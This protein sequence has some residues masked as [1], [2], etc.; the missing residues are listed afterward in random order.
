MGGPSVGALAD[1]D[2]APRELLGSGSDE[3]ASTSADPQ[4]LPR[5]SWSARCSLLRGLGARPCRATDD[6]PDRSLDREGP[7]LT[8]PLPPCRACDDD[9]VRRGRPPRDH[10]EA[11]PG[12]RRADRRLRCRRELGQAGD[13]VRRDDRCQDLEPTSGRSAAAI[14]SRAVA[15]RPRA[16]RNSEPHGNVTVTRS[17][18]PVSGVPGSDSTPA[19]RNR[20]LSTPA[21]RARRD[22]SAMTGAL[23]STPMTRALGSVAARRSTARPSPVPRSRITRFARAIRLVS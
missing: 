10:L 9:V 1:L 2:V 23:A 12:P 11:G 5:S 14:P 8:Q 7:S 3:V 13:A 22:A 4:A 16:P 21:R 18:V 17:A 6:E 20:A 15:S 19:A